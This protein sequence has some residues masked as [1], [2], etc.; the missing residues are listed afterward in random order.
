MDLPRGLFQRG[1]ANRQDCEKG[2]K[3]LQLLDPDANPGDT[4]VDLRRSSSSPLVDQPEQVA[5]P[6]PRL[7]PRHY[8]ES[9]LVAHQDKRHA[10]ISGQGQEPVEFGERLLLPGRNPEREGIEQDRVPSLRGVKDLVEIADLQCTPTA[11]PALPVEHDAPLQVLVPLHQGRSHVEDTL[12]SKRGC[13]PLG[14]SALPTAGATED[15]G[16]NGYS[17]SLNAATS[18]PFSSALLTATRKYSGPSPWKGPQPRTSTPRL[19]SRPGRPSGPR[20]SRKFAAPGKGCRPGRAS[21]APKRSLRRRATSATEVSAKPLSLTAAIPAAAATAFTG[22]EGWSAWTRAAASQT[23]QPSRRPGIAK[24]LV[25]DRATHSFS[26]TIGATLTSGT[27]SA[28][29]S[30]TM[31]TAPASFTRAAAS[32][33]SLW[34]RASPVGLF[35]LQRNTTEIP[36]RSPSESGSHPNP[37]PRR[38]AT[39]RT[40]AMPEA[41]AAAAYSEKVGSS[42]SAPPPFP[43]ALAARKSASAPPLVG[44]ILSAVT[45]R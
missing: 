37:S 34:S 20:A 45:P 21:S 30:S 11:R 28:K 8:P 40:G 2:H 12:A 4:E 9:D 10:E 33:T 14:E 32:R 43:A 38:R 13:Q 3:R 18:R 27:K 6:P 26:S 29:A 36:S 1:P 19:A 15:E 35:G 25:K 31:R 16:E 24:N 39:L 41:R 23:R 17:S 22:Q 42:T 5:K 7:A 44:T